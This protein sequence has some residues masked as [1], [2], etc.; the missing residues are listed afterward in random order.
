MRILG[1]LRGD[2]SYVKLIY[3]DVGGFSLFKK[4][5]RL[6]GILSL[7]NFIVNIWF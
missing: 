6:Y 1:F 7:L 4:V 2:R 3:V 5:G